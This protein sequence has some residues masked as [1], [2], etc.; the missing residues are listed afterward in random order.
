MNVTNAILTAKIV[1]IHQFNALHVS[2]NI[3]YNKQIKSA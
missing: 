1:L 2:T 3:F